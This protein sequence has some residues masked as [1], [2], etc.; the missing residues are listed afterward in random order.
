MKKA[1]LTGLFTVL[2]LACSLLVI[3]ACGG[4]TVNEL[5]FDS[6]NMPQIVFVQG[7]ELDL[8]KG[9]L[10]ADGSIV[11]MDSDG[12]EVTGYDKNTLGQQTLTVT[13]RGKSLPLNVTV[14]P[15]FEAAQ[16][17]VYFVGEKFADARPVINITRNDGTRITLS[18]N[19]NG[20]T[21]TNFDTSEP[22]ETL[23]LNATYMN[24]SDNYTGTFDIE[25]CEPVYRFNEPRTKAYGSH[26]T[27]LDL[28]GASLTITNEDGTAS[29]L[30]P[31]SSI[32]AKGFNPD[33]VNMDNPETTQTIEIFYNGTDTGMSYEITLTYSE[34]SH[35]LDFAAA[36]P[37]WADWN[38]YEPIDGEVPYL[39]MPDV[40]D[41]AMGEEAMELLD[42]YAKMSNN[43]RNYISQTN[44][45]TVARVGVIYGYNTWM[46]TLYGDNVI[47]K[48]FRV[49]S[50][51]LSEFSY[52]TEDTPLTAEDYLAA[53]AKLLNRE[54]TDATVNRL[55]EI[56]AILKQDILSD[57]LADTN[58]YNDS[59]IGVSPMSDI[60]YIVKDHSYFLSAGNLLN[61]AVNAYNMLED[62][63]SPA[64]HKGWM[65]EEMLQKLEAEKDT[66]T[67]AYSLLSG[68]IGDTESESNAYDVT[69]FT[70]VN[71]L[72]EDDDYFE[73]LYRYYINHMLNL[74]TSDED[75]NDQ[76]TSCLGAVSNLVTYYIPMPLTELALIYN[77]A[78]QYRL[79]LGA[80]ASLVEKGEDSVL[81]ETT[82]FMFAFNE[83]RTLT[84]EFMSTY[85]NTENA[86]DADLVYAYLYDQLPDLS[87]TYALLYSGD[88][89]YI[90]LTSSSAYDND[91]QGLWAK[92][93]DVWFDYLNDNELINSE[94][95]SEEAVA[96]RRKV[97]EL[98][99]AFALLDPIQQYYFMDSVSYLSSEGYPEIV[100]VPSDTGSIFTQLI[101][102]YYY[103]VL[104]IDSSAAETDTANTVFTSLMLAIEC[105]A[106]GDIENFY[107]YMDIAEQNFNLE[108]WT[109]NCNAETFTDALG[110][111]YDKYVDLMAMFDKQQALGEDDKP[112]VDEDGNPVYEYNYDDSALQPADKELLDNLN[113]AL[114]NTLTSSAAI[115]ELGLPVYMTYFA[116]FEQA[117]AIVENMDAENAALMQAFRNMPYDGSRDLYSIYYTVE[118]TLQ[119]LM[120][121]T[122]LNYEW[123]AGEES[124]AF[125]GF[126]AKYA[127]YYYMSTTLTVMSEGS[128]YVPYYTY[129]DGTSDDFDL[130]Y[131][132][133]RLTP[134]Y[135]SGMLSD[136]VALDHD[137]RYALVD[138]DELNLFL[139]G[140]TLGISFSD[141]KEN[142]DDGTT[143]EGNDTIEFKDSVMH[144][145]LDRLISAYIFLLTYEE[146]PD[147]VIEQTDSET[148]EVEQIPISKA[149]LIAYQNFQT[150]YNALASE[151]LKA[152]FDSYFELMMTFVKESCEKIQSST[153]AGGSGTESGE[154]AQA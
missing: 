18:G 50:S 143:D 55:E 114:G 123:Y 16:K 62:F 121:Q 64:E 132:A 7:Q 84:N 129:A 20:L 56:S 147:A 153:E 52:S 145:P 22:V 1:L 139:N 66:I 125:R 27:E 3:S 118:G 85:I 140:F 47:R 133:G 5:S 137:T 59:S 108:S 111:I 24:G 87:A 107:N 96:F 60:F 82:S 70:A 36:C 128:R 51:G 88:Y 43:D 46:K 32:T 141:M 78:D 37:T 127:E 134:E 94:N 104:G 89:G 99:K 49:T 2:A 105:Y 73:I 12:V 146:A 40:V 135:V 150:A 95:Q 68:M 63:Q 138:M 21:F 122:G 41:D 91:V 33:A 26:E 28:S 67:E 103:G 149:V 61:A 53:S 120:E 116:S 57:K 38:C 71:N 48:V 112:L 151:E 101:Y 117:R 54:G 83:A 109:G 72:R 13:Y 58:V 154:T 31:L 106:Y 11:Q 44:L 34:V 19:Y 131:A 29:R 115:S 30:I 45:E 25:V 93:F 152:E 8:S 39:N 142:A 65:T 148:G 113:R 79:M 144:L 130:D 92:Y 77:E 35:F 86:A 75:Y 4:K 69:I 119:L 102:T 110:D 76:M 136:Y 97:A 15:R 17:F 6:D 98:F 10:I 90:S 42:A 9:R 80:N 81:N 126:I 100:L 14:V 124:S 23:T 74:D